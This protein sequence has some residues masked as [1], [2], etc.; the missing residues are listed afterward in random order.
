LAYSVDSKTVI[1][2]GAGTFY[3]NLI[4]EGGMQSLE[5]NPPNNVRVSF[6]T[7]KSAPPTLFLSQGF[8]SN[9]LSLA[10]V[11][12][13]ELVSYDSKG[14]TPTDH[15]WNF[16]I[17]RELPGGVLLE[18]GYYGNKLDHMWRQIDGNPAPPEPGNINANR[19]FTS[20]VVPGTG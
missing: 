6:T 16:N 11:S 10:N 14:I 9:A 2:V 13:V 18:V 17:Q 12:N 19:R 1:H 8:A 20:T 15:Q 4:T 3:S 7:N 5:I